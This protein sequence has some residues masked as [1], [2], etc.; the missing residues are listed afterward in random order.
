MAGLSIVPPRQGK[1]WVE[2]TLP[3]H[4]GR[5]YGTKRPSLGGALPA[6]REAGK[7][8][9]ITSEKRKVLL[10][11]ESGETCDTCVRRGRL[12]KRQGIFGARGLSE[13]RSLENKPSRKGGGGEP[14]RVGEGNLLSFCILLASCSERG[15]KGE[16]YS[17][18]APVARSTYRGGA[19]SP[20]WEK[21]E[22]SDT[23]REG[24]RGFVKGKGKRY[25]PF[26]KRSPPEEVEDRQDPGGK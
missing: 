8:R 4:A 16:G 17:E 5:G 18:K 14:R 20:P 9:S 22:R 25:W 6:S 7:G 1:R 3:R 13:G 26:S 23:R 12:E 2:K 19:P 21:R 15:R 10:L 11:L 24:E